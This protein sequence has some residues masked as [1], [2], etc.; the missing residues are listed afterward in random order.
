MTSA[1]HHI[2]IGSSSS[3]SQKIIS[4]P[5]KRAQL[6]VSNKN[7]TNRKNDDEKDTH[8]DDQ[9]N[10][11]V[12]FSLKELSIMIE[13]DLDWKDNRDEED[14]SPVM[15]FES[16]DSYLLKCTKP[17]PISRDDGDDD[18][19]DTVSSILGIVEHQSLFQDRSQTIMKNEDNLTVE[20]EII[21]PDI[22]MCN[23][24]DDTSVSMIKNECL[25][26]HPQGDW[27]R[28]PRKINSNS[29]RGQ[30]DNVH[31]DNIINLPDASLKVFDLTHLQTQRRRRKNA[32][33]RNTR[34]IDFQL[35]T[36]GQICHLL[37]STLQCS[38]CDGHEIDS[39]CVSPWSKYHS[40]EGDM[41]NLCLKYDQVIGILMSNHVIQDD[42][43]NE[44]NTNWDDLERKELVELIN[45]RTGD[46]CPSYY[47][48]SVNNLKNNCFIKRL[49]AKKSEEENKNTM[50]HYD[51]EKNGVT[52]LI[53]RHITPRNQF[54]DQLYENS[55]ELHPGCLFEEV[56]IVGEDDRLSPT[57]Y[58]IVAPPYQNH[59]DIY[60]DLLSKVFMEPSTIES[61]INE[62]KSIPQWTAWP[63]RN[64][65]QSD[66]DQDVD[67]NNSAYPASWTVFPL[68]HTFPAND[69]SA[70]KWIE[71]TC[72]FV[73]Q[74]TALL[75]SL[76]PTLRTALFSRLEPRT[77][78]GSHTGRYIFVFNIRLHLCE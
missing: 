68:C 59:N 26:C 7:I 44:A 38:S 50:S 74:T 58:R 56:R 2:C 10:D 65:Y 35:D 39:H 78:L 48:Y 37:R 8:N 69:V 27:T 11:N 57:Q 36:P 64:H 33:N 5:T 12:V 29:R 54:Y 4:L 20:L 18:Y 47:L 42:D 52:L 75:R 61:I 24:D 46:A 14:E 28:Y 23:S 16:D 43:G 34:N 55:I 9:T 6:L 63:E 21:Q 19:E 53:F 66:Y 32:S 60:G 67:I 41:N 30:N 17:L 51:A 1:N 22:T 45:F 31:N 72:N 25:C 77:T 70:R 76:G 49:V 62:V 40:I 3:S 73:P 13:S 15:I 71:K